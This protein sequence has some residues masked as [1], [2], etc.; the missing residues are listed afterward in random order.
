MY[1][2]PH[3]ILI[4][5]SCSS[6]H[7]LY[8]KTWII[9]LQNLSQSTY[10]PRDI[11]SDGTLLGAAKFRNVV[12]TSIPNANVTTPERAIYRC[13]ME[14]GTACSAK[15]VTHRRVKTPLELS[16]WLW[17]TGEREI[18]IDKINRTT[19]SANS[20]RRASIGRLRFGFRLLRNRETRLKDT[21]RR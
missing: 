4:F 19:Y 12:I 11:P 9:L 18:M 20:P 1:L 14:R 10:F 16:P 5:K 15:Y 7:P 21:A 17:C 2:I 8:R 3:L 6:F 13:S